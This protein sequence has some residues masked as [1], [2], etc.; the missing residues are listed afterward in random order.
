M[1]DF[2]AGD[3]VKASWVG[4]AKA[5]PASEKIL[6]WTPHNTYALF[7][8]NSHEGYDFERVEEPVSDGYY[9]VKIGQGR[10][11]H[12]MKRENGVWYFTDT[13]TVYSDGNPITVLG[14]VEMR[15]EL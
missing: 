9:V 12:S 6:L 3:W 15:V 5:D 14:K 2:K 8:N 13:D 10:A 4:Q 7:V 1:S 11:H